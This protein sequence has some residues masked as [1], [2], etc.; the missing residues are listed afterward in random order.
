MAGIEEFI[1]RKIEFKESYEG[2]KNEPNLITI[3]SPDGVGKTEIARRVIEKLKEK[4]KNPDNVIYL[5]YTSLMNTESQRNIS[6]EIKKCKDKTIGSWDKN[7]IEHIIKLWAAKLNRSYNNHILPLIN[8]GK[9]V[10]LDR[11]EVDLFRACIEFGNEELLNKTSEYFKN[12]NLDQWSGYWKQ[13]IHFWLTRRHI[14]EFNQ[15]KR[16]TIC[17]RSKILR[18]NE[19]DV[20]QTRKS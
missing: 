6:T 17:K 20:Y 19:V 2:L 4:G 12:G 14:Y 5:K 18:R 1:K 9:I 16:T 7:K 15:K 3:D 13:N 11:S 8:D 10:I